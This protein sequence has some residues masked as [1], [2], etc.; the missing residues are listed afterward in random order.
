MPAQTAQSG[1]SVRDL[2]EKILE[3]QAAFID[4][5]GGG[6][7]GTP[8]DDSVTPAKMADGNFG[9]FTVA[10]NVA[11]LNADSVALTAIADIANNTVLGNISGGAASPTALTGV[12]LLT[13]SGA[14]AGAA[15]STDNA[16]ARY[17][18]TTGKVLQDSGITIADVGSNNVTI[19][20]VTNTALTL[21]T[22]D[23]NRNIVL[24][25]HGTGALLMPAGSE[26]SAALRWAA[27]SA[28]EGWYRS[29]GNQWTYLAA[30]FTSVF[31]FISSQIRSAIPINFSDGQSTLTADVGIFRSGV[32]AIKI[33]DA[34]SGFGALTAGATSVCA[35]TATPAGGSTAAR[36]L[37]GTTAGF[38]I[39]YG[40][41]DPSVSAAQGS[42]YIRSD[43]S[44]TAN[45]LWV[46]SNGTTGW[47][48]FV[49][50]A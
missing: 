4:G 21:A 19:T 35:A 26:T 40:S 20:P 32:G 2:L 11:T 42:L 18:S 34:G 13:I 28:G 7:G 48:N 33:T 9:A 5:G 12:N 30:A 29:G 50:A 27:D 25:P 43:G 37:L 49:S 46:N 38:G 17:D 24:A 10:A 22:L 16:I 41:G 23:N 36:L 47:T 31:S 8:D 14:A 45:R 15:S 44:G 6:G 3:N 1:D 39:Y